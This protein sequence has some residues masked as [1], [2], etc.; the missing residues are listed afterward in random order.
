MTRPHEPPRVDPRVL[1]PIL[2]V[3]V[4]VRLLTAAYWPAE[5]GLD[6]P[7]HQ[8]G[9]DVINTWAGPQLAFSGRLGLLFD[10]DAYPAAI[11]EL[12]GAPLPWHNWSYP[13]FSL[14]LFWP[15]AQLPY[16]AALAVWTFGLF[17]VFAAMT[18]SRIEQTKWPL[19]LILLV[20]APATL[21]N[22]VGG[23]NGFLTACLLIGG[24]L[25]LDRRP[26]LAGILFG[27][28]TYK[29]QLGL[30]VPFAL[31]ALGAWRTIAAAVATATLLI[32]A[33]ALMFGLDAWRSYFQLTAALQVRVL[34]QLG[35]FGLLMVTSV[36]VGV[37][38]TFGVSLQAAFVVQIA[39]AV[40]VV[41]L[42]VWAIR[43]TS[44]P[45]R[46]AFV[47]VAATLLATPYALVYDF[48]ALTAV[49]TWRL[50]RPQ[51]LGAV[52][53]AIILVAWLMPV[54]AIY[55]NMFDLGLAPLALLAVFAIAVSDAVADRVPSRR[56]VPSRRTPAL[57]GPSAA[58]SR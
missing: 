25:L 38:R 22:T 5:G 49:M 47:L 2:S 32:A 57:S 41:A 34:E 24:V 43:Q 9:G 54:G 16:F 42:A 23:Q 6:V 33:S 58:P 30:V 3:L 7:H 8:I 31:L 35:D 17:A 4:C 18:L 40:P 45:A 51:P 20:L 21:I 12:F 28:L 11:S 13:L 26:V 39:V 15:L 46:R 10:F 48:C 1:F 29:P 36:M 53:T 52:R 37:T 19:A 44:D 27:L 14:L 55:L 50:F 56:W